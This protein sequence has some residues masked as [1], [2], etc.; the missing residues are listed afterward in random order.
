MID[1][2]VSYMGLKLPTPIVVASSGLT[3]QIDKVKSFVKAGAGAIVLKSL[4]EEQISQEANFL[5]SKSMEYTEASDYL[6]FYTRHNALEK[7]LVLIREIKDAVDVPVI[8]SI[9]CYDTGAWTAF[10]KEIEQAGA[11]GIELNIYSIPLSLTKK[12]ED[13]EKE[14]IKVVKMV[15]DSI[16]IPVSVKI[17]K[18]FT[19]ITGMI[20]SL[21]AH[22][23]K[24]VIMFNRFYLPDID[25]NNLKI[26]PSE[27]F[28]S[29]EEYIKN[30]RWTALASSLV[31]G[32]DISAATGI[33]NGTGALKHILAGAGT[34]QICS[35]LY[36]QGASA[37]EEILGD[38]TLFMDKQGFK[39]I[40]DFKGMLN[41]SSI[42]DPEKFE[43]VQFIRSFGSKK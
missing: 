30:I 36:K 19:N 32:I 1:L 25:I 21:K 34:I 35:V 3:T 29:S 28:S 5:D 38:I 2:S 9:N 24:A 39:K 16:K 31:K 4:F 18:Y 12:S 7:Y 13:I 22:G 42:D 40:S 26:V 6:H 43:R 8:A 20:S 37:I 14:Y 27:A 23:A 11:D 15:S 10:A 33:H 17:G 41:Y